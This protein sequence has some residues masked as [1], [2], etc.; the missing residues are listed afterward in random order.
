[1]IRMHQKS[2]GT[3]SKKGEGGMSSFSLDVGASR[4]LPFVDG[5]DLSPWLS[6]TFEEMG[7]RQRPQPL[8]FA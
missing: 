1:M 8:S 4:S 6:T 5:G 7:P 2:D 3:E